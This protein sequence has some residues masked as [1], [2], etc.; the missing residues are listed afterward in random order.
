MKPI[1]DAV[2]EENDITKKSAKEYFDLLFAVIS[3]QLDKDEKISIPDLG[4]F[5]PVKH[6]SRYAHNPQTG[7]KI[8]VAPKI[9]VSFKQAKTVKDSLND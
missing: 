4:T 8:F 6:E 7:E 1:I 3:T 5:K 2:A 9:H